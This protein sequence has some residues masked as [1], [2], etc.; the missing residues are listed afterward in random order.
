LTTGQKPAE[1]LRLIIPSAPTLVK[2]L[3]GELHGT[4][5]MLAVEVTVVPQAELNEV[6]SKQRS[7]VGLV[8]I[9]VTLVEHY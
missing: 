8:V 2:H 4:V 9:V 7:S 1:Q 5:S 3:F 6:H